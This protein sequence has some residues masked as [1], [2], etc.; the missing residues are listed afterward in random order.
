MRLIPRV[1]QASLAL[2]ITGFLVILA[3]VV[4]LRQ[5]T[6]P[7]SLIIKPYPGTSGWGFGPAWMMG[8]G[9]SMLVN[10]DLTNS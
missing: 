2:S 4:F 5:H 3:L 7:V 9:N 8:I 10:R 1:L 6:Q